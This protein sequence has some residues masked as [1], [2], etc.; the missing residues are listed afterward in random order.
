MGSRRSPVNFALASQYTTPRMITSVYPRP[1]H[2][3]LVERLSTPPFGARPRRWV[4][5]DDNQQHY[6]GVVRLSEGP[7]VLELRWK[8]TADGE[9][10]LV[11]LFRMHLSELLAGDYVRFERKGEP[12]DEVRVR[13]FRGYGG[14]VYVQSRGDGPGL[15][16]GS[17]TLR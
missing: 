2:R 8:P 13:F 11:G 6:H 3:H 16:V 1:E 7:L 4:L 5:R 10:Q 12:G 9:E 15:A 17:V 14:V